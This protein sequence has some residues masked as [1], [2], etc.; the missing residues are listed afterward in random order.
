MGDKAMSIKLQI[1]I[2]SPLTAEDHGLLTGISVMVLAIANM[3]LAQQ[4]FPEA[5]PEEDE[6][7]RCGAIEITTGF[8]CVDEVGHKGRHRF[9]DAFGDAVATE[10][11]DPTA[12]N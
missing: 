9:R 2:Q 10:T 4:R 5:F 1:D 8:R 11:G 7:Q 3:P 6:P 12:V